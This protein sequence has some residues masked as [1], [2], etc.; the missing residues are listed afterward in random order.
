MRKGYGPTDCSYHLPFARFIAMVKEGI[1]I[2][3]GVDDNNKVLYGTLQKDLS[4]DSM[5]RIFDDADCVCYHG[6]I[7]MIIPKAHA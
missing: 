5:R 2:A 6:G 7:E 4:E 3:Q 1:N